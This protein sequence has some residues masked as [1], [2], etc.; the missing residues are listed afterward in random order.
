MIY[1][2]FAAL[3]LALCLLVPSAAA[4]FEG[5][6]YPLEAAADARPAKKPIKWVD[7]TV[8]AP[9]MRQALEWDVKKHAAGSNCAGW[10]ELLAYLGAKCGGDFTK[11]KPRTMQQLLEKLNCGETMESLAKGMKLYGYYLE[12]YSAVLGGLAGPFAVEV[13]TDGEKRWEEKYGL[14]AFHPIARGFDYNHYDDFGSGRNYG[15]KRKHLG[16]DIMALTGTP[17]AAVESGIVEELGWNQYGGWRVGVRSF[18]RKRYYYY[19]H[20]RQNRPYAEG[21]TKGGTVLAGDVIGYVGRTGYSRRE[22]TNGITQS[23]LHFG[24]QLIFDEAQKDGDNQ[25]WIDPYEI[26]KLL[27]HH[28][29]AVM[30][31]PETKEFTRTVP[32]KEALSESGQEEPVPLPPSETDTCG[33]PCPLPVIMYHSVLKDAAKRGMYTIMPYEL[34]EDLKWLAENGY[35]TVTTDELIQFAETGQPLKEK[36]VLLTFDDGHYNNAH[37]AGPLLKKYGCT[38]LLFVV[39]EFI[40]KSEK[41]GCQNPNFS[42]ASRETL[43][44]MAKEGIWEIGSHS[45]YLHRNKNGREGVKRARGESDGHYDSVLREDFTKIGELIQS[46]TERPPRAFAYPFGALSREADEVLREMG[47]K[48]TF[49][50]VSGISEV[51]ACKPDTLFRLKRL[52]RRSGKPVSRLLAAYAKGTG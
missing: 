51:R 27:A 26:T 39:G 17:V 21:L 41:E 18:D 46:V 36:P 49:S 25:I 35:Q 8:P 14:R 23:H 4:S 44:N 50:C 32:Y 34:E 6:V 3:T 16:H 37:Y 20:L 52:L 1:R 31:N 24:I 48:L 33:G 10:I 5:A 42:Y 9:V 40:E 22:N 11:H 45:Y 19:A 43:A 38:A 15:Y 29:S 2:R 30:R 47:Y 7:F 12:A 28:R 13:E